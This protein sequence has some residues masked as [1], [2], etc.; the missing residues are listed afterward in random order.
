MPVA[1]RRT[2]PSSILPTPAYA[3]AGGP[4]QDQSRDLMQA[5]PLLPTL[6]VN[7]S[8]MAEFIAAAPPCFA[9]G[10]VEVEGKP[11][12]LVA[13]RPGQ[14]IPSSVTAK[15]FRFGHALLGTDSWE[16]V[17]FGFEF[18]GFGTFH[19]LINPSDPVARAVLGAMVRTGDYFF[20]A[21]SSDRS[22]TAFRSDMGA[23]S[24][25]GLKANMARIRAST[26]NDAQYE[27][28]ASQFARRPEPPGT[29]LRWVCRA[30]T[31]H[32]DLRH[33]RLVL[34]PA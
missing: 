5:G 3:V 24:L 13:L 33:D 17:H 28:A 16:V 2:C 15:G 19:A 25:A 23:G 22:T 6:A 21:P 32:L 10:L 31:D 27:G 34:N 14:A 12:A 4:T 30:N 8:F 7:R 18:Y 11:C 26:T 29:M 20:F 9:L 1:R